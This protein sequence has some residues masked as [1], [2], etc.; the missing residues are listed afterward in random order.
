MDDWAELERALGEMAGSGAVE[1]RE[2][3]EWLAGLSALHYELR[4]S[5]KSALV[6][7]WSDE[8]NLTRRI[9]GIKEQSS[10]RLVLEVQRFGR[11]RPA[12][13][14]FLRT[15]S[16]R[17]A[18]RVTREQF[19]A[20]FRRFLAERFP[21]S[22]VDSLIVSPDLEHSFSGVYV[23]GR[24]HEGS[25]EHALIA[26]APGENS[27]AIE[28]ILTFG[29][30][31]IDWARGHAC[32]RAVE[33]L[34]VFVPEGASRFIRERALGLAPG[35]RLEVFEFNEPE[36]RLQKMDS[37][38]VG[39]LESR[40]V[41]RREVEFALANAREAMDRV[42]SLAPRGSESGPERHASHCFRNE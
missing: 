13:L 12:R 36:S 10:E 11:A 32:K 2:D 22:V 5:G 29:V 37:A 25:G 18:G 3:G 40:L 9:V 31:W 26:V 23:R 38:D 7:L 20:R 30:L 16:P 19:R 28:G 24:M 39:N 35:V 17:S 42:R 27:A 41:P 14:E 1:V 34:R 21:D 15:D 4:R 33:G 8:R 6:H